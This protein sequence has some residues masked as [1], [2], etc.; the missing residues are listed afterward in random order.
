ML[1]YAKCTLQK[2]AFGG[3]EGTF[4]IPEHSFAPSLDDSLELLSITCT[5]DGVV[6]LHGFIHLLLYV[7]TTPVIVIH[8]G[9]VS[10]FLKV[11]T[12][13]FYLPG[14]DGSCSSAHQPRGTCKETPTKPK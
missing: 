11:A 5:L 8:I 4:G 9:L 6:S 13:V 10:I 12:H 2:F 7:Y 1:G 3:C 14:L